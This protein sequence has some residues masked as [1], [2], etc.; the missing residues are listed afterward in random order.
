[1]YQKSSGQQPPKAMQAAVAKYEQAKL[2]QIAIGVS[3][4]GGIM[5][6]NL[7]AQ[8]REAVKAL[9]KNAPAII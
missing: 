4:S 5:P 2:E 3:N 1:M 8:Q 7:T 9:I 6:R